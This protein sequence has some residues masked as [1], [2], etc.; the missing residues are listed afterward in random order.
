MQNQGAAGVGH[1][2]IDL[3]HRTLRLGV[4]CY[5][6]LGVGI[7][8]EPSD[9]VGGGAV[10]GRGDG[11]GDDEAA[12][13][14]GECGGAPASAEGRR[15]PR[16]RRGRPRVDPESAPLRRGNRRESAHRTNS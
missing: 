3:G 4:Q 15:R 6:E 2:E 1:L 14:D 13:G 10:G 7:Q 8:G 5:L 11:A 16:R 9:K 12:A